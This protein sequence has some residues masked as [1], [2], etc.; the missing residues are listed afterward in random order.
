MRARDAM[1]AALVSHA[2]AGLCALTLSCQVAHAAPWTPATAQTS[3]SSA[4][5]SKR[6]GSRALR[7]PGPPASA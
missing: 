3:P 7:R 2:L 5:R 4:A 6:G 1:R